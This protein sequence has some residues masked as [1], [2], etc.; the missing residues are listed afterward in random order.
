MDSTMKQFRLVFGGWS[1]YLYCTCGHDTES[2]VNGF[3]L[4]LIHSSKAPV[5]GREVSWLSTGWYWSRDSWKGLELCTLSLVFPYFMVQLVKNLVTWEDLQGKAFVY[6]TG[7]VWSPTSSSPLSSLDMK[8][9]ATTSLHFAFFSSVRATKTK[10]Q[11]DILP[12]LS[13]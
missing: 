10:W 7:L 12:F 9:N 11:F 6:R 2:V 3:S 8:Q 13:Q 4:F 1:S 5:I